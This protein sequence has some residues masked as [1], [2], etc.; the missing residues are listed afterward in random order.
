MF[1][2]VEWLDGRDSGTYSVV[3]TENILNFIC[4]DYLDGLDKSDGIYVVEWAEGKKP[5]GGWLTYTAKII[6]VAERASY[7]ESY[8]QAMQ[9]DAE[10]GE[11]WKPPSKRMVK[12][13]SKYQDN[14]ASTSQE[15]LQQGKSDIPVIRSPP[16]QECY[17]PQPGSSGRSGRGFLSGRLPL[18]T[19]PDR[20]Q[21]NRNLVDSLNQPQ[22]AFRYYIRRFVWI[23]CLENKHL[24]NCS[25]FRAVRDVSVLS[26]NADDQ[27]LL[28][29]MMEQKDHVRNRLGKKNR[30]SP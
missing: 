28:E 17:L 8:L 27:T 4:K 5:K 25:E 16:T 3:M 14:I 18:A 13:N 23:F 22:V 20:G 6:K 24:N 7:L 15:T 10:V 2:L 30:K 9:E 29:Q 1:A 26:L 21:R 12:P 19:P 11:E